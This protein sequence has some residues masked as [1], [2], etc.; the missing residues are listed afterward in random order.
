[1]NISQ[2]EVL[3]NRI[4]D[5]I[6]SGL[7]PHMLSTFSNHQFN[8]DVIN[9]E[10]KN[11]NLCFHEN[12]ISNLSDVYRSIRLENVLKLTFSILLFDCSLILIFAL[13]A[14]YRTAKRRLAFLR[15]TGGSQ[16]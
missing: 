5:L 9:K 2:L 3:N 13:R 14:V 6:E 12:N 1:M 10:N 11:Y 16:V 8:I 7:V 4:Y 15:W